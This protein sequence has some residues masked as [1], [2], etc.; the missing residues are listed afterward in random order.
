MTEGYYMKRTSFSAL[1]VVLA[2]VATCICGTYSYA[3]DK[4]VNLRFSNQFAPTSGNS[5]VLEQWSKE[6]EKRTNGKVKIKYFPGGTL[7]SPPQA[8]DSVVQG[9]VDLSNHILGYTAGKFPLSE[10]LDYPMGITSGYG[11]TK[12]LNAYY[13]QFKPKEFDEVKVMYFHGQGPGILHTRTK[14]VN[15]LEDLKGMKIRTFGSNAKL[16]TLLGGTP[17]AMPMQEAYDAISRGVADGLMAGYE[18]LIGWKIGEVIKYSTECLGVSYTATFVVTM[19]KAKWASI[20]AES[21]KIIEQI[22]QE[23]IEKHGHLWD[24]WD[25]EGKEFSTKRGNKVIKLSA[26]ENARWAA[27]AQPLFDD[28]VKRT[29]EKGLPGDEVIKF[30]RG[31]IKTQSK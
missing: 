20:P 8:Y 27:K 1:F 10:V 12:M 26:E 28:Y 5:T 13:K 23:W 4:V 11:A 24:Q 16:M 25:R 19:N 9:V 7:N 21:Q 17:V 31:Y 3:Q 18:P 6:V 14:P 29:K 2:F 15:K 30:V 22:N